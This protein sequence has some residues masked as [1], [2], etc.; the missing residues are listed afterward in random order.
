MATLNLRRGDTFDKAFVL[1]DATGAA[2]DLTGC[3]ARM[4]VRD[5]RTKA[6]LATATMGAE[7]TITPAEG[8]VQ[9][10]L[11]AAVTEVF[12]PGRL[13]LDV[14]ITYSNGKVWSTPTF[15]LDVDEDV[16]YD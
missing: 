10:T 5:R 9:V 6:L 7:I 4:Y 14:E 12:P 3:T 11:P 2:I 8:R 15:T 16:T 13:I 1:K